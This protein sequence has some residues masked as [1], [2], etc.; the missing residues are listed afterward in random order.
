M[1]HEPRYFYLDST[2]SPEERH[3]YHQDVMDDVRRFTYFPHVGLTI[4]QRLIENHEPFQRESW[5][6]YLAQPD[7]FYKLFATILYSINIHPTEKCLEHYVIYLELSYTH[8]LVQLPLTAIV[9][10]WRAGWPRQGKDVREYTELPWRA[11]RPLHDLLQGTITWDECKVRL[12]HPQGLLATSLMTHYETIVYPQLITI[13]ALNAEHLLRIRTWYDELMSRAH[14][15]LKHAYRHPVRGGWI[16][17]GTTIQFES[18]DFKE[19]TPDNNPLLALAIA[20]KEE[21]L[22]RW[23]LADQ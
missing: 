8:Q 16:Y 20:Y 7:G 9:E 10:W 3:R 17:T 5:K 23:Q 18:I 2:L 11:L 21:M 15:D 19:D 1:T 14:D 13:K 12:Y 6:T 4:D 22:Q